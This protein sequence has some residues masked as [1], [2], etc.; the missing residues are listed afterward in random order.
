MLQGRCYETEQ[1]L[2]FRRGG[3]YLLSGG[4]GGIG[5]EVAKYLLKQYQ[6]RLLLVGR[7]N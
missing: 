2:P 4:L 7:M 1:P 5:V 3:L 6:A